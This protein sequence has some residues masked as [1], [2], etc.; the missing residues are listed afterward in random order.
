ML[1]SIEHGKSFITS[2]PGLPARLR[3]RLFIIHAFSMPS[4]VNLISK[5]TNLVLVYQFT[6]WFIPHTND[7]DV[8]IDFCVDSAS[9]ATSS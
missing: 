2:G 6:R 8:I 4:L 9:L 3:E 7:Y 5:D 1:S